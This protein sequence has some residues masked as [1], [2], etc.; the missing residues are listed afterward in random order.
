MIGKFTSCVVVLLF[1]VT[2]SATE[3]IADK[4]VY[5]GKVHELRA[6]TGAA[7]YPLEIYY[8]G[9]K[10][11]RPQFRQSPAAPE[12][13]VLLGTNCW[14]GYVATWEIEGKQFFLKEI[15][16]FVGA[17]KADAGK[18][19]NRKAE[20]GRISASWYSGKVRIPVGRVI[21]D[22][23]MERHRVHERYL[24]LEIKDGKVVAEEVVRSPTQKQK[25]PDG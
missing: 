7:I 13:P 22:H 14:R 16:G 2:L 15:R 18:L 12:G 20:N 9:R 17:Q 24:I 8:K 21:Q 19:L 10:E 1:P 4:V 6:P 25:A 23:F 5:Q 11:K 3:Q